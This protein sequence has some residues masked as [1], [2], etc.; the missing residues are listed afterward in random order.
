MCVLL[1]TVFATAVVGGKSC[2]Q[3]QSITALSLGWQANRLSSFQDHDGSALEPHSALNPANP[4]KYARLCPVA[5]G[6]WNGKDPQ[7][8]ADWMRLHAAHRDG[9]AFLS[10]IAGDRGGRHAPSPS[11]TWSGALAKGLGG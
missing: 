1:S 8:T 11:C 3:T 10:T 6:R 5:R 4:V 7:R 2:M 9:K